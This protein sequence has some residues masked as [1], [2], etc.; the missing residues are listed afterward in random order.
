MVS[1]IKSSALLSKLAVASSN[2]SNSGLIDNALASP[3]LCFCPPLNFTPFPPTLVCSPSGQLATTS[4][5][6]TYLQI[7]TI[8]SS[9]IP[10]KLIFAARVPLK[11]TAYCG[12]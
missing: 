7:S 11:I 2:N 5:I 4:Q 3:I 12:T 10:P 8:L 6:P 1:H 9:S